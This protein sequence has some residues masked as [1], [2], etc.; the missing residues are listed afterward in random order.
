M[1]KTLLVIAAFTMS[2]LPIQTIAFAENGVTQAMTHSSLFENHEFG[3]TVKIDSTHV[4]QVFSAQIELLQDPAKIKA[5]MQRLP[6]ELDQ[7]TFDLL[8]V[9][10]LDGEGKPLVNVPA[11]ISIQANNLRGDLEKVLFLTPD[12]EYR[13]LPFSSTK[14]TIQFKT[15]KVN[16]FAFVYKKSEV[17]KTQDK[18]DKLEEVVSLSQSHTEKRLEE[19]ITLSTTQQSDSLNKIASLSDETQTSEQPKSELP[20]LVL[21]KAVTESKPKEEP[22]NDKPNET[23]TPPVVVVEPTVPVVVQ[24]E[25]TPEPPQPEIEKVEKAGTGVT[26]EEAPVFDLLADADGDGF[27]NGSE[28]MFNT[29]PENSESI[30]PLPNTDYERGAFF[31]NRETA[32]SFADAHVE[33]K[34]RTYTIVEKVDETGRT[35]FDIEFKSIFGTA[36]VVPGNETPE[37][38]QPD[39]AATTPDSSQ[40]N[41]TTPPTPEE[42][43]PAE[44]PSEQPT[45]QPDE[46]PVPSNEG[47]PVGVEPSVNPSEALPEEH[48]TLLENGYVYKG[49]EGEGHIYEKVSETLPESQVE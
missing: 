44:S 14:E 19:V 3:V 35:Y 39:N 31:L 43:Q 45:T 22:K 34:D 17:V 15:D 25:P 49:I 12:N 37:P 2:G 38:S 8:L 33:G 28:L 13:T 10:L 9:R 7:E 6:E 40:P 26:A 47:V 24:P 36:P 18:R 20:R 46:A 5:W 1:K 41:E 16:E 23:P 11:D 27:T 30:P 21:N 4:Q 48:A 29:D 32:K 42:G